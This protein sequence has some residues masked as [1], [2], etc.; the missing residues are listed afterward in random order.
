MLTYEQWE[1][2]YYNDPMFADRPTLEQLGVDVDH[3][4]Y[5]C[6]IEMVTYKSRPFKRSGIEPRQ[7]MI[8]NTAYYHSHKT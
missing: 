1:E 2:N 8:G 3:E 5:I 6:Q 7:D 4:A